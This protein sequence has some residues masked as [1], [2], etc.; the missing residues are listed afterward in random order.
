[1][2]TSMPPTKKLKTQKNPVMRQDLPTVFGV[3]TNSTDEYE[4]QQCCFN[5]IVDSVEAT[6]LRRSAPNLYALTDQLCLVSLRDAI[7]DI[8]RK[9]HRA[10]STLISIDS[11]LV[12]YRVT[13]AGCGLRKYGT[14]SFIHWTL[15]GN[16]ATHFTE[17]LHKILA[18]NA[19]LSLDVVKLLHEHGGGGN[20]PSKME[21]CT[22]HSHGKDE[23]CTLV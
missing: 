3:P 11:I 17:S 16:E 4:C 13:P 19:D 7:I 6:V 18:H 15:K 12:I 23:P 2:S 8:V 21:T 9:Y 1:M 20:N 10:T 14:L 5:S 22:F